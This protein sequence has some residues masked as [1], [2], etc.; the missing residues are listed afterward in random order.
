M[1]IKEYSYLNSIVMEDIV[2]SLMVRLNSKFEMKLEKQNIL[3]LDENSDI[4]SSRP[5]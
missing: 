2:I 5:P 3:K 1:Q 4:T